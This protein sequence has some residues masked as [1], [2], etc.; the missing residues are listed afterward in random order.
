MTSAIGSLSPVH[1]QAFGTTKALQS[2]HKGGTSFSLPSVAANQAPPNQ[3]ARS[4]PGNL[5]SHPLLAH[6]AQSKK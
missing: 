3:P 4:S 5:V 2:H 6:L 1:S